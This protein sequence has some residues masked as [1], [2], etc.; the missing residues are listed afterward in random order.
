MFTVGCICY[1]PYGQRMWDRSE[2]QRETH[3]AFLKNWAQ[4][5]WA[6]TTLDPL[7]PECSLT[8]DVQNGVSLVEVGTSQA[9]QRAGSPLRFS[10]IDYLDK[11][12]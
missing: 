4:Q 6:A 7:R 5:S 11:T 1:G 2:K 3:S 12:V 10:F 9:P 8:L